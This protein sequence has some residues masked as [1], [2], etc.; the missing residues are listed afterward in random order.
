MSSSP[1]MFGDTISEI[2]LLAVCAFLFLRNLRNRPGVAL[3]SAGVGFTAALGALHYLGFAQSAGPHRFFIIISSCAALPLL[4]EALGFPNGEP[5]RTRR[6][7][8]LFLFMASLVAVVLVV[9]LRFELWAQ[10]APGLATV[11]ILV[12]AVRAR[13]LHV[14]IGALILIATF[15]L[16]KSGIT[17]K[18]L[19]AAQ[20]LHY[21]LAIG[22]LLMGGFRA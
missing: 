3:A 4:A 16:M 13:R 20:V 9:G 1:S 18:P 7:A 17:L 8:G 11:F 15:A 19:N 12:M 14:V 21:G 2:V 6:G 5:A 22:L 10:I